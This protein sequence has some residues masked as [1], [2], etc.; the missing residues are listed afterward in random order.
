[1]APSLLRPRALLAAL[2]CAGGMTASLQREAHAEP[3]ADFFV[4]LHYEL[5]D[6][7]LGCWDE[8]EFRRGVAQALG[9]NPFRSDT[10]IAVEVRVVGSASRIDGR[11]DWKTQG[12]S[13]G[14]RR[15]VA[16]DGNCAKLLTEMSFA[17]GM[18]IDLLRP[19]RGADSAASGTDRASSDALNRSSSAAQPATAARSSAPGSAVQAPPP[20]SATREHRGRASN[21]SAGWRMWLGAGPALAWGLS[22]ST[23]ARGRLFVGAGSADLS[24]ELGAVATLPVVDHQPDGGGFR[25]SLLAGSMA[26]CAQR[27]VLSACLLGQ[28]GSIRVSGVD[29]DQPR[30]PSAFVA[31]AGVRL[32]ATWGLSE[33]WFIQ[34]PIEA[35]GLL[36]PRTISLRRRDVWEMPTLSLSV[37][38]DLAARFR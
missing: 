21:A 11:V 14:E 3:A 19:Q 30:A 1:R 16:K 7:N 26:L 37:G 2:A 18:Q 24:L 35:L 34:A 27:A 17:V 32:G 6:P 25:E 5:E 22:P 8:R 28:A 31:H 9:Y 10:A 12:G 4:T 29:L 20:A 33:R 15:F 38:I 13:M 23:T 36:T